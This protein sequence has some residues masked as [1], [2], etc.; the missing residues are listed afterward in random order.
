M[1]TL[2]RFRL[3]AIRLTLLV[4]FLAAGIAYVFDPVAAKG[5]MA[6]G[7]CGAV[8][9]WLN[10]RNAEKLA[11]M[12]RAKVNSSVYRSTLIRMGLYALAFYWSFT[13][14]RETM[15][16][17]FGALARDSADLMAGV[18]PSVPL[19]RDVRGRETLLAIDRARQLLGYEPRHTWRDE[20][21]RSAAE[22]D[23]AAG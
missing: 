15:Y 3:M 1:R 12:T 13:L 2:Q 9:F 7:I 20:L 14:D 6:G 16:G 18:F 21:E 8:G 5:L 4:T 17:L 22:P 23:S 11:F 19:T 10:A